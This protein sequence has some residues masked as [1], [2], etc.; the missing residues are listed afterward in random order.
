MKIS[1]ESEEK[2]LI[3]AIESQLTGLIKSGVKSTKGEAENLRLETS[4]GLDDRCHP[5][6]SSDWFVE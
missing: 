3:V 6:L 4:F 5:L 1:S 2:S